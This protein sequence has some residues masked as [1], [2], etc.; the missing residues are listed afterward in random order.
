VNTLDI[1][2]AILL[3]FGLIRGYFQ[4]FIIEI[5]SLASLIVGIYVAMHFSHF[6]ANI[7][8]DI[9]DLKPSIVQIVSFAGTFFIVVVAIGLAGKL[10]TRLAEGIHL[11]FVNNILGAVFGLLKMAL[12]MSIVLIVFD[13]LNSTIPFVSKEKLDDSELYEPVKNFGIKI[14]PKMIQVKED[15]EEKV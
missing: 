10:F 7:L 14:F 4:G 15:I 8:K 13:K 3:V 12:I 2:M 1:I 11:G 5:A 6:L 9:G